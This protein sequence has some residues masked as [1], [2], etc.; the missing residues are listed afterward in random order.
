M[1]IKK[2]QLALA[3]GLA[4]V[5]TA[6]AQSI[7]PAYSYPT[8]PPKEGAASVR[9]GDSPLYF[10]PWL[11]LA[12]GHDSNVLLTETN[13]LSSP[14]YVVSPGFKIDARSANSVFQVFEQLQVGRYTDSEDDSYTDNVTRLQFDTAF[15]GRSFLRLGGDYIR[16]HDP[17]GSTDR[18]ISATPD[19]YNL[20]GGNAT[21]AYGAPGAQG[22]V[23]LY[24]SDTHKRYINNRETTQFSD[25]NTLEYGGAFYWRVAP[26]TY[27]MAE[28]RQTNIDYRIASP[29]SGDEQRYFIGV[30]WEATA[31]TTGTLKFGQLRR[32][33]DSGIPSEDS[34]SWEGLISWAPRTY[35]R[36]DFYT[37]RGTNE[38]TGVGN[39]ILSDYYGVNWTHDWSSVLSTGANARYQKDEYKGFPRSDDTTTLGFR[40]GY[41]F[42][43]WLTLGAEYTYTNRDSNFPGV[44]YDKN[45]Y[46]LTA[47]ASM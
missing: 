14:L 27:A 33:F 11:G 23:E 7:R 26:R 3:V 34:A 16:G 39:Y 10:T 29:N 43:R 5:G 44:E 8:T 28:L 15:S 45:L 4:I 20:W 41:K 21:Y 9:M 6:H 32:K 31:A 22:R 17:R 25:R 30:Q 36:F 2:S 42:R 35:S 37:A 1:T 38:S 18:A 47:T 24:A 12:V 13:E 46:L 40:V 19:K